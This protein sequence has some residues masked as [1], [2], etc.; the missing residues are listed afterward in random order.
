MPKRPKHCART[1]R[2]PAISDSDVAALVKRTESRALEG[3]MA[4]EEEEPDNRQAATREAVT[5]FFRAVEQVKKPSNLAAALS[6]ASNA[7]QQMNARALGLHGIQLS[8]S[9]FAEAALAYTS[10]H[11]PKHSQASHI[12]SA[13]Q[14]LLELKPKGAMESMLALQLIRAHVEA[15]SALDRAGNSTTTE[16]S[17]LYG[18]RATRFMRLSAHLA[19]TLARLQ[20]KISHQR[21]I[22]EK[23]DVNS[24]GQAIV[25]HVTG[26]GGEGRGED[27]E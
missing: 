24:G 20:G 7:G 27:P 6:G 13:W 10:R 12:I 18:N 25:G 16:A 3:M 19:E 8:D 15:M 26:G 11:K 14:C 23:V 9:F 2:V 21:I 1:E 5:A 4:R 22:V 17:E